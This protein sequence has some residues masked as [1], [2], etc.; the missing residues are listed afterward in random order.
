MVF[1]LANETRKF[2]SLCFLPTASRVYVYM[3]MESGRNIFVH[4]ENFSWVGEGGGA[5]EREKER[6]G[7]K[8]DKTKT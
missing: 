8:I 7:K 2:L 6:I 3:R 1:N 4:F 5:S